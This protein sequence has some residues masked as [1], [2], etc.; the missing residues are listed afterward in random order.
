MKHLVTATHLL[1]S[2]RPDQYLVRLALDIGNRLVA[3]EA[4][5][6]LKFRQDGLDSSLDARLPR[7][8]EPIRVRAANY[9]NRQ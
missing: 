6:D 2:L 1:H 7:D 9:S 3:S 4:E 5:R 8:R